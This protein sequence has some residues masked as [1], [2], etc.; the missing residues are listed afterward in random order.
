MDVKTSHTN[1]KSRK[2]VVCNIDMELTSLCFTA[3]AFEIYM[4]ML[5][6]LLRLII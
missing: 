5:G 4:K 3:E 1:L 6:G 2:K